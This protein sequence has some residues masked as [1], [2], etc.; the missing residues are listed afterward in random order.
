MRREWIVALV[1]VLGGCS[2]GAP[3]DSPS[4]SSA[5]AAVDSPPAAQ[6]EGPHKEVIAPP[7][8]STS[9]PYSPGIR[10]GNLI[11]LSGAIGSAEGG[12]GLVE[13]IGR[14]HV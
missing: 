1:F 8:A 7:G 11:F 2:A 10:T 9:G 12:G 14:A 6:T 13:E 5:E 4:N 3:S